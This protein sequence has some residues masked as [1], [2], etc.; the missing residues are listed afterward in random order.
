M[1]SSLIPYT[2]TREKQK[3]CFLNLSSL[4]SRGITP[5]F[6]RQWW[7]RAVAWWGGLP[8]TVGVCVLWAHAAAGGSG[9]L[10]GQGSGVIQEVGPGLGDP[11]AQQARHGML[12][13]CSPSHCAH[14]YTHPHCTRA[15]TLT[16]AYVSTHNI[17][18][19]QSALTVASALYSLFYW[20]YLL[21]QNSLKN[22]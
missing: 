3:F 2:I 16:R 17:C 4:D 8:S 10:G 18:S 1:L 9:S 19:S 22:K 6:S 14:A 12:C 7:M 5:A 20:I 21:W 11:G 13:T 15:H